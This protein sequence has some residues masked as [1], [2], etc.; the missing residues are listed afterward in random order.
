MAG[1]VRYISIAP[2][3]LQNNT[4]DADRLIGELKTQ[5]NTDAIDI[6]LYL[7]KRLPD[8]LRRCKYN[9]NCILF[10]DRERWLVT[11]VAHPQDINPIYDLAVDL[12]TTR[13]VL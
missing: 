6:D 2:P 11:G 10:K 12:G 9:V 4:A 7:L 8:L 13:I 5:L 3:N 1:W